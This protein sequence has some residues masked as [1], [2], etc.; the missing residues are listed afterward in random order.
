LLSALEQLRRFQSGRRLQCVVLAVI[1]S[2]MV[3]NSPCRVPFPQRIIDAGDECILFLQYDAEISRYR[4][5]G[6]PYGVLR[7]RGDRVESLT[8]EAADG[9]DDIDSD[10]IA[11]MARLERLV[12]DKQ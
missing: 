4:P 9:R 1:F 8:Q 2:W 6:G 12:A 11:F 10:V 3:L 7:L 5:T